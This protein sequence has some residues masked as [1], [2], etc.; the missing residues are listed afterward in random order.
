MRN[1]SL[2]TPSSSRRWIATFLWAA[3]VIGI[4]GSG[5]YLGGKPVAEKFATH[6]VMPVS[7]LFLGLIALGL[8]A[9]SQR[10]GKLSFAVFLLAGAYWV[11]SCPAL[12]YQVMYRLENQVPSHVFGEGDRLDGIVVL[13]GSTGRDPMGRAQLSGAGDRV[14]WAAQ[15]FHTGRTATLITSGDAIQALAMA[16]EDPSDETIE[17]WTKLAIQRDKIETLAGRN[18]LEEMQDLK[19][20]GELWNGKRIGLLTSAFHMPRAMRLAKSQGLE[21]IPISC[22]FRARPH[23]TIPLDWFPGAGA[24]AQNELL[25]KEYLAAMVGR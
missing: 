16:G 5:W 4:P 1:S 21:L 14:A 18:T 8:H 11:V 3:I 17:I 15:L 6:M 2:E 22:D 19:S 23:V 20:R 25:L 10:A 13:G 7:L 12:S 24:L 9:W